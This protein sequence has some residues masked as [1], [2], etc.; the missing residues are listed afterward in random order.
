MEDVV[1]L[2]SPPVSSRGYSTTLSSRLDEHSYG[3]RL[4]L[5]L[6]AKR[7]RGPRV[8]SP[9]LAHLPRLSSYVEHDAQP[10]NIYATIPLPFQPSPPAERAVRNENCFTT[11]KVCLLPFRPTRIRASARFLPGHRQIFF[12]YANKRTIGILNAELP[13][14]D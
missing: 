4:A 13:W 7:I 8:P 14:L 3:A 11:R 1:D 12:S 10:R 6:H 5:S 9:P 2:N